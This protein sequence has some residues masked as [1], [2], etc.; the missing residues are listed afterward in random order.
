MLTLNTNIQSLTKQNE[1]NTTG[2]TMGV[3]A[4][5]IAPRELSGINLPLAALAADDSVSAEKVKAAIA[6]ATTTTEE[7]DPSADVDQLAAVLPQ[8]SSWLGEGD[9]IRAAADN[10]MLTGAGSLLARTRALRP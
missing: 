7:W 2:S 9:A 3:S 4:E 5:L 6:E 8:T 1:L 10:Y